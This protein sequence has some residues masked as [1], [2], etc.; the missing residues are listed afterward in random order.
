ML[1][2]FF[3]KLL[4][5]FTAAALLTF[6][7]GPAGGLGWLAK[8]LAIDFGAA[9]LAV[10]VWPHIR[11]VAKGDKIFVVDAGAPI[12]MLL[13][14]GIT[15]ARALDSGRIG[16]SVKVEL[17]DGSIGFAEIISYEGILSD[18]KARLLERTVPIEIKG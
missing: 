7:L 4:V 16:Q 18:A 6:G 13:G 2:G 17:M 5:T 3:F 10:V 9:L 1:M 8:L 12:I 11:G 14:L 15:N